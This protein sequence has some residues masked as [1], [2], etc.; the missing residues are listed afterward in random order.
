MRAIRSAGPIGAAGGR[1]PRI[2]P[3]SAP[4]GSVAARIVAAVVVVAGGPPAAAGDGP[5][6]LGS[7]VRQVVVVV[8]P[9]WEATT[10]RLGW[11]DRGVAGGWRLAAA[12]VAVTV[13][14][15][16]C[17]WGEGL[18]P[19]GIPGPGKREGDG[20]SPAGVFAIGV[21]FGAPP[22]LDTGLPYR[23]L[24][25]DDWCI[26]VASSPLY[27]RVVSRRDVGGAAVVGS[28]EPMRRDLTPTADRQYTVGFTIGHN[29]RGLAGMGSCIFAHVVAGPGVPTSGCTGMEEPD[30]R[31][32]L[33][34]L[35]GAARPVFVMVPETEAGRLDGWGLPTARDLAT[36]PVSR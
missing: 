10:G 28:T 27:N 16:G 18:H 32:L 24:D 17:G 23:P 13:G 5:L 22:T 26:D 14:R 4:A 34:W 15:A 9:S 6:P 2:M 20:R 7:D 29:P 36:E 3:G 1:L 35:Q 21:A 11:F 19:G 8:T 30:L 25:G 33:A 12:P 31:R